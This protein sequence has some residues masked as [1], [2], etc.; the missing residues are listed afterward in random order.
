MFPPHPSF[1]AAAGRYGGERVH[2][3]LCPFKA[4]C[5]SR[6]QAA[7]MK[8]IW[9]IR[10]C[11]PVLST[12]LCCSVQQVFKRRTQTGLEWSDSCYDVPSILHTSGFSGLDGTTLPESCIMYLSFLPRQRWS[13]QW[14]RGAG[15]PGVPDLEAAVNR[16]RDR[17]SG[18]HTHTHTHAGSQVVAN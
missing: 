6:A 12:A 10:P 8:L 5:A 14:F 16:V 7:A 3:S 17:P 2:C 13:G 4:Q 9:H 1:L 15:G 18:T 11:E